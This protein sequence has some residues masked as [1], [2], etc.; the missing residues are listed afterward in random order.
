MKLCKIL[1]LFYSVSLFS[2][3]G[4]GTTEPLATLDINGD[5][6]IRE[7]VE[8]LDLKI[9]EDSVLVIAKNGTVRR[10]A[11]KNIIRAGLKSAVKGVFSPVVNTNLS[12]SLG[13][14]TVP[15]DEE[16]FDLNEEFDVASHQFIA[17][18][19]GIYDVF[20]QVKT[21]G[22]LA[23]SSNFGISIF[24]NNQEVCKNS[25]TNIGVLGISVSSP[26]RSAK[27]LLKLDAGDT[28]TFKI[29]S[30]LVS[31]NLLSVD[32]ENYFTINQIR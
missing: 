29:T 20:A 10:I 28:I 8:E 17:K 26:I 6:R 14:A 9:A 7:I 15:F 1:F 11:A 2:Q 25:Y 12:L 23:A 24:K 4:I 18:N 16:E 22:V 3:V 13:Y 27:A 31:V 5:L 21:N 19:E 30:N 32:T